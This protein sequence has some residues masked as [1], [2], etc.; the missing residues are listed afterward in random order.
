MKD[1]KIF[2]HYM[3]ELKKHFDKREKCNNFITELC[4]DNAFITFDGGIVEEYI[5]L[6]GEVF[7]DTKNIKA[8]NWI[9]WIEWF[10]YEN[11][12][13]KG[14]LEAGYDGNMKP[15]VTI[16][17]LWDVIVKPKP[18]NVSNVEYIDLEKIFKFGIQ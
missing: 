12:F 15:I 17:D 9:D 2:E 13:G 6:M 14:N 3:E 18:D 4:D 1:Y 8:K 5:H 16:K 7:D 11:D 10:I